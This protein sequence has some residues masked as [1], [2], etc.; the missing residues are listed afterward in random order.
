MVRRRFGFTLIELLVV[1]AIIGVLIALLL[2]A[3]QQA[4]EAA[5]RTQCA[6]NLKQIGLA[7]ANYESAYNGFPPAG[8]GTNYA[9]TPPVTQ[10]IDGLGCLPRLMQFIDQGQIYD[11]INFDLDYNYDGSAPADGNNAHA[12]TSA[13]GSVVKAFVCPSSQ[14][15]PDNNGKDAPDP[16]DSGFT[17]GVQDYGATCYTDIDPTGQTGG[18]GS[19]P[20]VPYRNKNARVDGLM[21]TGL[22]PLGQITDGLSHTI[23]IAEDAGR[24]ARFASPYKEEVIVAGQPDV[25]RPVPQGQRRFWRWAEADGAF[26]VS[27]PP[28]NAGF[29]ANCVNQYCNSGSGPYTDP[30]YTGSPSIKGNNASNNDEMFSYHLGGVHVLYGDGHVSF[31]GN[32]TDVVIIR[33]LVS[34]AGAELNVGDP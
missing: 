14:R 17:Y 27:G 10:F 34:A 3:V 29:P 18:L 21:A 30:L 24:D 16:N 5:R 7:L 15:K 4:R 8:E 2:P 33:A 1:I 13:Y 19:T 12:N 20:I 28:N 9:Y 11:L 23:A 25:Q 6:N 31:L 22:R 32:S 26:G